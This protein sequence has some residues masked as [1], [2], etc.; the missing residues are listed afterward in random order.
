MKEIRFEGFNSRELKTIGDLLSKI[1]DHSADISTDDIKIIVDENTGDV[2]VVTQNNVRV[3]VNSDNKLEQRYL[4]NGT[5]IEDTYEALAEKYRAG[6]LKDEQDVKELCDIAKAHG[7][8]VMYQRL[9]AHQHY[10]EQVTAIKRGKL[11]EEEITALHLT[12]CLLNDKRVMEIINE[13]R[14][15]CYER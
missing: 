13:M 6:E 12:A 1:G 10:E 2:C 3:T 14:K 8:K 4:L 7:D 9:H 5:K 15:R 11:N